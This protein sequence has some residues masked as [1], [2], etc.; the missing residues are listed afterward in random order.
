MIFKMVKTTEK[1]QGISVAGNNVKWVIA[2]A[3]DKN[4]GNEQLF[5]FGVERTAFTDA[6]T[7]EGAYAL[8][9]TFDFHSED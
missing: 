9:L 5:D 1:L 2:A 3:K 7:I 4:T 8:N 6:A